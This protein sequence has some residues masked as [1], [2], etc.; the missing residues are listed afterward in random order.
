MQAAPGAGL[1]NRAVIL[2]LSRNQAGQFDYGIPN[3]T[4][5][6]YNEAKKD[7]QF[8]IREY[9]KER[10]V[11]DAGIKQQLDDDAKRYARGLSAN[12]VR[13]NS[14]DR[15]KAG[16]VTVTIDLDTGK[17]ASATP[18]VVWAGRTPDEASRLF[19]GGDRLVDMY[20]EAGGAIV[21]SHF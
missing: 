4:T 11:Q 16:T 18:Y 21:K 5:D 8:N 19:Y 2:I 10:V 12:Q 20:Y 13:F 14:T 1:Q 17:I 3:L 9:I 6:I 7:F 15:A